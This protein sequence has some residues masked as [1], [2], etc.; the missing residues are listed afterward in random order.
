MTLEDIKDEVVEKGAWYL[1]WRTTIW[2]VVWFAAGIFGGNAD[3]IKDYVPTLKYSNE[4][5][6]QATDEYNELKQKLLK[7]KEELD[8]AKE[9]EV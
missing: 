6:Q 8:K 9:D 3:R 5:I 7:A 4:E 2:G 1:R